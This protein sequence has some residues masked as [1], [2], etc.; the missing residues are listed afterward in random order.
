[1][2]SKKGN[3]NYKKNIYGVL[4]MNKKYLWR[5]SKREMAKVNKSFLGG[6]Q[7]REMAKVK[8]VSMEGFKK[9]K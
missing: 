6:F 9:G 8:K 3:N 4:K 2:V 7:K 5:V 1:M